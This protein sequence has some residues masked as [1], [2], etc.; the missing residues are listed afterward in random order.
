[1]YIS[2]V[3]MSL[4]ITSLRKIL[5]CNPEWMQCAANYKVDRLRFSNTK[6]IKSIQYNIQNDFVGG[7][8]YSIYELV[9]TFQNETISNLAK[10]KTI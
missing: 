5:G 8:N 6:Y 9:S 2:E 7:Y 10:F 4:K 3:H 1:M